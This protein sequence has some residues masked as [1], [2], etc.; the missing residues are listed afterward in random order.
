MRKNFECGE[1]NGKRMQGMLV[2]QNVFSMC[3]KSWREWK[4]RSSQSFEMVQTIE[5][6]C[7]RIHKNYIVL[8]ILAINL[9]KE[10]HKR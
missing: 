9:R 4:D 6:K 5:G 8:K 7:R 1:D 10:K 3:G 2:L